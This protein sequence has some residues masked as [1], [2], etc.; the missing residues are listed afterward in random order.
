MWMKRKRIWIDRFQ[1]FLCVRLCI[2]FLCYQAAVWLLFVVGRLL[3]TNL[4]LLLGGPLTYWL[5]S[6][7]GCVAIVCLLFLYDTVKFS[8]RLVGPLYRFRKI[9]Q[10]I[11]AGEEVPLVQLRKD[12]FL[13]ELKDEINDMLRALEQRGAVVIKGKAP[14]KKDAPCPLSV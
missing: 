11:T 6:L 13:Q 12:D 14:E 5:V 4:G 1:T 7:V 8:H 9:V 10:A 3:L 2:L